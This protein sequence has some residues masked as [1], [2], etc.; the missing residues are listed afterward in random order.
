MLVV[1]SKHPEGCALMFVVFSK[2]PG[3]ASTDVHGI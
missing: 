1:F 2:Y 3:Q